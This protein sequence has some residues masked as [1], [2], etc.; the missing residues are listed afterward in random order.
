MPNFDHRYE[1]AP[2]SLPPSGADAQN[3]PLHSGDVVR[4]ERIPEWLTHDLPKADAD[5]IRTCED[6][7]VRILEIDAFGY[8]WF[9]DEDPWFCLRHEDVSSIAG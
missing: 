8:L 3:Q 1:S 9:G 5:L 2:P 6:L 4:I 7:E